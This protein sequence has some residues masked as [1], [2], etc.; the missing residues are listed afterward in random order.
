MIWCATPPDL[1]P[2]STSAQT[3]WLDLSESE[4]QLSGIELRRIFRNET[5]RECWA[6]AEIDIGIDPSDLKLLQISL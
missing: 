5:M 3:D 2:A 1:R 6:F 4:R